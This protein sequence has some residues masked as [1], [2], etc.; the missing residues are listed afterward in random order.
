MYRTREKLASASGPH[1]KALLPK[2]LSDRRQGAC[3]IVTHFSGIEATTMAAQIARPY[4]NSI[5]LLPNSWS[6]L[7][8]A[9]P[10][11]SALFSR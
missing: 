8:R 2:H 3:V 6:A 1:R 10:Y 5:F 11:S 7:I 4:Y 9:Q